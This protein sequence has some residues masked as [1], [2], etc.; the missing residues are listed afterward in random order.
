MYKRDTVRMG[1][2][3]TFPGSLESRKVRVLILGSVLRGAHTHAHRN[4]IRIRR[5][6]ERREGRWKVPTSVPRDGGWII[7]NE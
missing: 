2:V 1:K 6:L 3:D 4:E 5:W 7:A